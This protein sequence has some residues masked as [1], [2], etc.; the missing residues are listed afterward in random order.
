MARQRD[1]ILRNSL[2]Q[3]RLIEDLLD[4]SRIISGKL[5]L[6]TATVDVGEV[7]HSALDAIRPAAA[8][9]DIEIRSVLTPNSRLVGD[10]DR[11]RQIAWNLLSNAVRFTPKHGRVDVRV[12]QVESQIRL[13]VT[14]TG[15]GVEPEFLPHLFERFTQADSS[16][17]RRHGG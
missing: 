6:R 16:M 11:L 3:V 12:E 17:T 2:A 8:A 5:R 7:V 10:S 15:I 14:D 9:K 1:T 13:S 4:V